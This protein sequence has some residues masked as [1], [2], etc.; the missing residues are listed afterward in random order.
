MNWATNRC[1]QGYVGGLIGDLTR[2][3]FFRK[4]TIRRAATGA[5]KGAAGW[6]GLAV[7]CAGG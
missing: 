6:V 7:A 1:I 4:Q 3:R 2:K 5:L